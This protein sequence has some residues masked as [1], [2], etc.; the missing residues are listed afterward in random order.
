M[1]QRNPVRRGV[2]SRRRRLKASA[3]AAP[4]RGELIGLR[5]PGSVRTLSDSPRP[6]RRARRRVARRRQ[7]AAD[8]RG[9]VAAAKIGAGAGAPRRLVRRGAHQ[10][11][12]PH[13]S[14]GRNHRRRVQSRVRR[15]STS[16]R[17]RPEARRRRSRPNSRSTAAARASLIVG[18]EPGIGELAAWLVGMRHPIEFK[19]GAVCRIDVE[20][21]R[22]AA[23]SA[24]LAADAEDTSQPQE[25]A[26][27]GV[28]LLERSSVDEPIAQ[29]R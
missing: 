20:A 29:V 15:S 9:H 4:P 18:H 14:D 5:M 13:A 28:Q 16:T 25:I 10:S 19:K 26:S 8:R 17:W 23:G 11:A 1:H 12:G 21:C 27:R 24:A 6:G 2:R 22:R 7:A 3:A